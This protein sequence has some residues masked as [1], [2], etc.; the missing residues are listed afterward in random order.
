MTTNNKPRIEARILKG[1]RDE[2]PPDAEERDALFNS[3]ASI[4]K[5]SGFGPIDTPC[6]EYSEVLLGK[7]SDETDKQL[8]R[9]EDQGGRDV[10][11]RF[12]LTVPLARYVSQHQND[13]CFPF[14]RYHIAPVWRAEKPQKGRYR[15]FYQCD[16]DI[17]G[18]TGLTSDLE[19]LLVVHRVFQHIGIPYRV[20]LNHRGLLAAI[21]E[22][23]GFEAHATEA[24]RAIDKLEKQGKAVVLKELCSAAQANEEDAENLVAF[25]SQ[26]QAI[27]E[28]LEALDLIKEKCAP[29]ERLS[30]SLERMRSLFH[31]FKSSH[32]SPDSYTL[33]I[34]I[35]RGLDYYTGIVFETQVLEMPSLG[36]VCSGGRYD[37]LT[38]LFSSRVLPGVGGS[39]GIDRLLVA[40]REKTNTKSQESNT[41]VLVCVLDDAL[42]P[43]YLSVTQ[44]L[45]ENNIPTEI[46]PD[47]SKLASQLKYA[48]KKNIPLAIIA[49]EDEISNNHFQIKDLRNTQNVKQPSMLELNCS[50]QE[51]LEKITTL[52]IRSQNG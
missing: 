28:P 38:S 43:H 2:L 51:L 20:R 31:A 36:S 7:G 12:D 30:H 42:L 19:V 8:F 35:A 40:L 17:I 23:F 33:D 22:T 50:G 46:F 37:D 16:F 24:L 27:I 15:E 4:F 9:F 32:I 48:N 25:I 34:S 45:R 49:G 10:A 41:K 18:S 29:S 21:L 52:L 39:V 47:S 11:L 26:L 6:L 1:F 13:L 44:K 3:I 14:R 5:L